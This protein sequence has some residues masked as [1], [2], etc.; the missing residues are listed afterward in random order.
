MIKKVLSVIFSRKAESE[1]KTETPMNSENSED[2]NEASAI[3]EKSLPENSTSK[4]VNDFD[5]K[6]EDANLEHLSKI[7]NLPPNLP[8]EVIQLAAINDAFLQGVMSL[9]KMNLDEDLFISAVSD[10]KKKYDK[11]RHPYVQKQIGSSQEK[12]T[13]TLDKPM[14]NG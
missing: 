7:N 4:I 12:D 13:I 1:Y 11:V 2:G 5:E 3:S 10:L 8:N 14:L 6:I 9:R